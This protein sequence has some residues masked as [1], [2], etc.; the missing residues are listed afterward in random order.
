MRVLADERE[1]RVPLLQADVPTVLRHELG[2]TEMTN[3]VPIQQPSCA[4]DAHTGKLKTATCK[5]FGCSDDGIR[6]YNVSL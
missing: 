5:H 6:R 1:M 3:S 4:S 2:N